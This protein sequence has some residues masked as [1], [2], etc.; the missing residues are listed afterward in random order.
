MVATVE[1]S[2]KLGK[3]NSSPTDSFTSSFRNRFKGVRMRSRGKWVSEIRL[4]NCRDRLWLG[5]FSSAEQAARA[6]DVAPVSRSPEPVAGGELSPEPACRQGRRAVAGGELS[7]EPSRS[8]AVTGNELS[9]E[10]VGVEL[11]PE[12]SR[13]RNRVIARARRSRAIAGSELSPEPSCRRTPAVAGPRRLSSPVQSRERS[14]MAHPH[15]IG[16]L[17]ISIT[18]CRQGE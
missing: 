18:T 7:P 17:F 3:F 2:S 12:S 13:R 1:R 4:P 14:N 8:R 6:F 5:F 16:P 15:L 9:P 11:S 10:P